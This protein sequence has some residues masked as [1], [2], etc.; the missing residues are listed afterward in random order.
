MRRKPLHRRRELEADVL[1]DTARGHPRGNVDR[2]F[3][4]SVREKDWEATQGCEP[5]LPVSLAQG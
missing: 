1:G 5:R 2:D 4:A 3:L